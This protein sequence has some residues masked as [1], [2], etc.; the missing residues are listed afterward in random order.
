MIAERTQPR[1]TCNLE[2]DKRL[3]T[4]H[5]KP[6][7]VQAP[8]C[9]YAARGRGAE[10]QMRS[11][12]SRS[13]SAVALPL[14]PIQAFPPIRLPLAPWRRSRSRRLRFTPSPSS[15]T[16]TL[17][18]SMWHSCIC[19]LVLAALGRHVQVSLNSLLPSGRVH[20]ILGISCWNDARLPRR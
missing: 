1:S 16:G 10:R 19:V 8:S 15:T 4:P 18:S 7:K 2:S 9:R 3:C 12:L 13:S 14:K 11:S 17:L 20:G 5:T 6:A